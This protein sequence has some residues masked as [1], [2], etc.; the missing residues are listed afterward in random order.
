MGPARSR[1]A[2]RL[3]P[4]LETGESV[5]TARRVRG[6]DVLPVALAFGVVAGLGE[7][8]LNLTRLFLL[9]RL[10]FRPSSMIWWVPAIDGALFVLCG[11][12]LLLL[13]RVSGG[14]IGGRSVIGVLVAVAMV[15]WLLT[16]GSLHWI[17]GL[18][19]GA[20]VGAVL[21]RFLPPI[22]WF[23]RP[24]LV[25]VAIVVLLVPTAFLITT[26][27]ARSA[28]QHGPVRPNVLLLVLDTVR[29]LNLSAYGYGRS[30]TPRLD[31]WGRKGVRFENAL[32]ASPW[33]LPSHAT[34]FTGR[35][36][37]E[38]SANWLSP[39][40]G[41]FPTLA[42]VLAGAGYR[43]AGVVGNLYYCH[44]ESGLARGF[45]SYR[46]YPS[47]RLATA[48][49]SATL[50][51]RLLDSGPVRRALGNQPVW[52]RSAEEINR[53]VLGWLEGNG[54]GAPFFMFVNYYD[55][56]DPYE[57]R[58][59]FLGRFGPDRP[60]PDEH[61]L[62]AM[63]APLPD[64]LLRVSVDRYDESLAYLDQQ[65]GLLL[66]EMQVRGLLDNTIVIVVG[67]HGEQF[68]EHDLVNHGNSLYVQALQV[69]LWI[70]WPGRVPG[71]RT[72]P[73]AVTLR[74]IPA[75]VLDLVGVTP[76]AGPPGRSLA[77]LWSGGSPPARDP[78]FM[79]VDWTP[80]LTERSPLQ[81]GD[82]TAVLIDSLWYIRDGAGREE[83][84]DM[85]RDAGQT[86]NLAGTL[87][88]AGVLAVF[89]DQ[90]RR[91]GRLEAR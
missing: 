51:R 27:E 11:A 33:T 9:D 66:H 53:D 60:A 71:N 6:R 3:H 37:Y 34:L 84:Y 87:E 40:D 1:L 43:T 49:E 88:E 62:A 7:V 29:A 58:P 45:Q 74:D 55:V 10:T 64:S 50:T 85:V 69:P 46:A 91:A 5:T 42:E 32:A 25:T 22:Q 20:G 61:T 63:P 70:V 68:G 13:T 76:H 15:V 31:E 12:V 41:T 4:I 83:V 54:G 19:L 59:G 30:T 18:L 44:R 52:R 24:A 75:T 65:I 14:R 72:V 90:L 47:G 26:V 78:I 86:T 73:E 23:G 57:P 81:A 67:D 56:H 89:R 39:L 16:I 21:A 8:A 77:P 28:G 82:M 38:L 36:P 80:G 17:S 35:W 2:I 48:L 79:A